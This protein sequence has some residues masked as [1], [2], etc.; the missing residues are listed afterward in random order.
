MKL[1]VGVIYGGRS[2]ECDISVNTGME[3]INNL[4]NDTSALVN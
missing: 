1:N 2:N 3:I 4:D